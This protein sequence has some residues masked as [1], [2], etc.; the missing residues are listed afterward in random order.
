[1]IAREAQL[2]DLTGRA[3]VVAGGSRGIGL[4]IANG[5]AKAGADVFV[6]G[7]SPKPMAPINNGGRYVIADL[8]TDAKAAMAKVAHEAGTIDGLVNCAGVSLGQVDP[9]NEISRFRNTIDANLNLAYNSCLE[10]IPLM[11]DGASI[12]NVTSINSVLG[13]PGNPGYVS[14]KGALRMLTRALAVD[15]G[16]RGIRVNALAPGYIRTEMTAASYADPHENE[17]RRAHTCLGRWGEPED[18]VGAAIFLLSDASAYVTGTDLFVDGGWTAKG[19][20]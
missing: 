11:K 16:A 5:L 1:M 12:V 13:F 15:L 10:A 20:V 4:S 2:F 19:L 17:R 18:L 8:L 14:A 3:I 9:E 6:I 7:R